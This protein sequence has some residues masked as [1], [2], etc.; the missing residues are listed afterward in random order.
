MQIKAEW[1]SLNH[2]LMHLPGN[3]I[4]Y[5]MF[6]PTAFLFERPFNYSSAVNEHLHLQQI[7]KEN[8]I[9]VDILSDLVEK[10]AETDHD[11]REN[12][13]NIVRSRIHFYGTV[14]SLENAQRYLENNIGHIDS[15][16]LFE[17]LIMELSIDLKKYVTGIEYPTVYSNLPLANLY[18]MRDQQA[19]SNGVI[20]GNMRMQ[21]RRKET[22]ITSFIFKNI[23]KENIRKIENGYF[24][25]GDFIP[26]GN[27]AL[28]GTGN[29]TDHAGALDAMNS[30]A[31]NF[32][33]IALI[34]N[35]VYDLMNDNDVMMNMHL[36]TYF[37]IPA[38]GLAIT[39]ET[40]IRN[41]HADIYVRNDGVYTKEYETNFYDYIKR[42][43][44][45]IINLGISEQLSYSSNFLTLKNK[46]IIAIDTKKIIKKLLG[47]NVFNDMIKQAVLK[48]IE[49][50]DKVFPD[51]KEISEYGI[52]VIKID[53]SE[54]TGGYGGA[55]CMTSALNRI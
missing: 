55:H 47:E 2:V 5:A 36:D 9:K 33:E 37:N 27:F 43:G 21:Q 24:E 3:E 45:D 51:N 54:L 30:G 22:E 10:T 39:S 28:I 11:F 31:L 4:T 8:G 13:E 53:L 38:N 25:G 20:I 18:F 17:A 12:L 50:R 49:K 26:A 19:V 48:D 6:A 14:E 46:K 16:S 40:L 35:P 23:F 41:A 29:R 32:E 34:Q 1:D 52:D 15:R 42:K 44:Y 7:L